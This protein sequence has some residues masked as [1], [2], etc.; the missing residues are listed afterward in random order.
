VESFS[1]APSKD[2]W[3]LPVDIITAVNEHHCWVFWER[4][5]VQNRIQELLQLGHIERHPDDK[6]DTEE[7]RYRVRY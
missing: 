4:L 2:E 6:N 3:I 5:E 1:H 7:A